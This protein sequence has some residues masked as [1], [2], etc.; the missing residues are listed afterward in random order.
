MPSSRSSPLVPL[1]TL[2][3][4]AVA[5][6]GLRDLRRRWP[7]GADRLFVLAGGGFLLAVAGT[8]PFAPGLE[9]LV[10][11]VPG[12]GL[13][14]DGQKFL[15]PYALTVALGFALGAELL[16][17]K[18]ARR[19]EPA[20]GGVLLTGAVLLPIV[21]LP[22]LAFGGAG[23]L[24][25]VRYPADWNAVAKLVAAAPGEVLSWPFEGYQSY[26]WTRGVVVRDPAPRYLD[27]P[28]LMNDALRVGAVTVD[29]ES[30]RAARA[31]EHLAA[32]RP[33]AA[34]GVRWVLVRRGTQDEPPAGVL[35]GLRLAYDGPYLRLWENPSAAAAEPAP[36]TRRVPAL[37]AHLL[38]IT[39]VIFASLFFYYAHG[40]TRGT[41]RALTNPRRSRHGQSGHVH[42]RHRSR[43]RPWRRRRRSDGRCGQPVR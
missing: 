5:V 20:L 24:R 43:R 28:V 16:A 29:G 12:A 31:A 9:W 41:V 32:G 37:V 11:H 21:L 33:A 39:I 42:S 30:P 7:G 6:V 3:L 26:P 38:A 17:D 25:P 23:A 27:A 40:E 36:A 34:L 15:I 22:D 4:L 1:V 18:L 2:V 19:F 14:R 35:A 8:G 10:G 13:L